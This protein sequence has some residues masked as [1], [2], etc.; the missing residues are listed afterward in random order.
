MKQKCCVSV[1]SMP[2]QMHPKAGN[3]PFGNWKKSAKCAIPAGCICQDRHRLALRWI[4]WAGIS[5]ESASATSESIVPLS[6]WSGELHLPKNMNLSGSCIWAAIASC[7]SGSTALPDDDRDSIAVWR[8]PRQRHDQAI[9]QLAPLDQT[10]YFSCF[11][12]R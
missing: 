12:H 6:G 3:S 1:I 9:A 7:N 2:K 5:T 10:T 8:V 11:M 4:F